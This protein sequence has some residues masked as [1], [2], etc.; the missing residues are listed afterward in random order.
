MIAY[1]NRTREVK[2][3]SGKSVSWF[4]RTGQGL[5]PL[6]NSSCACGPAEPSRKS[7]T[8]DEFIARA[9]APGR[10]TAH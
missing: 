8:R 7:L 9:K 4:T 1:F 3:R 6:A 5:E 2:A 10:D